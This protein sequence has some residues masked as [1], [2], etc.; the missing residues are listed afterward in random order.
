MRVLTFRGLLW[1]NPLEN[2]NSKIL[3]SNSTD[4][5]LHQKDNEPTDFNDDFKHTDQQTKVTY[6]KNV[7]LI[8][9]LRN[10]MVS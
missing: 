5:N 10:E 4:N 2:I 8:K 3:P 9:I 6:G 1:S 7:N